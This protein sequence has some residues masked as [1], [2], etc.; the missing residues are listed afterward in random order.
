MSAALT[1]P[2]YGQIELLS[3]GQVEELVDQLRA[4]MGL[5]DEASAER[6]D[7]AR[8]LESKKETAPGLR[9]SNR[10]THPW[11]SGQWPQRN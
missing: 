5:R 3:N 6:N 1:G 9:S 2:W 4:M 8:Y 10:Y 7:L 11:P